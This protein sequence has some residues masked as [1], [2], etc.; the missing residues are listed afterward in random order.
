METR[1]GPPGNARTEGTMDTL[2]LVTR[3]LHI[4]AAVILAGGI[5]FWQLVWLPSL[6]SAPSAA[7]EALAIEMGEMGRYHHPAVAADT[8]SGTPCSNILD[9]DFARPGLSWMGGD[10]AGPGARAV[11]LGGVAGRSHGTGPA[12]CAPGLRPGA[13]SRPCLALVIILVGGYDAV[14]T[15]YAHGRR[16]RST[17]PA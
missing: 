1:T 11:R 7:F 2:N 14:D 15:A 12:R 9:Y 8:D 13:A 6:T 4:L 5:F 17:N 10:Q 3:W 16:T